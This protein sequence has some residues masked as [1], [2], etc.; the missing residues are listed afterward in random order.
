M[1]VNN[2]NTLKQGKQ[3]MAVIINKLV[4]GSMGV[5]ASEV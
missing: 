4:T 1:M 2:I 5:G 3:E